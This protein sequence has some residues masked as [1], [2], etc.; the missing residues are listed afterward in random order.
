VVTE[1]IAALSQ[2]RDLCLDVNVST[3]S[4]DDEGFGTWVVESLRRA[5]VVARR[6]GVEITETAAISNLDAARRLAVTPTGAGGR[7]SLDDFGAGFGSFAYLKHLPFTTV[8]IAGEFVRQADSP[9]A[10]RVLVD[11]VVR[12]ANGLGMTTVA[13]YVDRAPLVN[14]LRD[15]GVNRGQG[16]YL[17]RPGRLEDLLAK[18]RT[19]PGPTQRIRLPSQRP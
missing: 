14:A 3:R 1:A 6:L 10:D 16:Y 7:F 13:E 11:A 18:H 8:K 5:G 2:A 12:A 9:G 4:I 17:G 19:E 15:L